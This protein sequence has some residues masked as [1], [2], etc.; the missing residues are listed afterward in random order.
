MFAQDWSDIGTVSVGLE[1]QPLGS[2]NDGLGVMDRLALRLEQVEAQLHG[3][4]VY[5]RAVDCLQQI[6]AERGADV[7]ML[8]RAIGREA[9]R[10][11][12]Q[13]SNNDDATVIQV[14]QM[15]VVVEIDSDPRLSEATLGSDLAQ[16]TDSG[17]TVGKLNALQT[18]ILKC[19]RKSPAEAV[20]AEPL[21]PTREQCLIALGQAVAKAREEKTMTLA[22]LHART[23][24]PLYHLQAL[25]RGEV[26]RLPQDIYLKGFLRRI[27]NALV[28]ESG[29]LMAYLP[30]EEALESGIL[31]SWVK[32]KAI[33]PKPSKNIAGLEVNSAHLYLA[34]TAIMAGGICW[35]SGQSA[36]KNN[37]API[38]I[39]EFR[40]NG[41]PVQVK[42]DSLRL[43]KTTAAQSSKGHQATKAK[44]PIKVSVAPPE[45]MR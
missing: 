45:A 3:S 32:G 16:A 40:P 10:L 2:A 43:P 20:E 38:Q 41:A 25:E 36:P 8:I 11:A 5:G 34:Y 14:T 23:F 29:T 42:A 37:L 13:A 21:P 44:A 18:L 39:D 1:V 9:I 15:P 12:L 35:I 27:E 30:D 31:P 19:Q 24:V 4:D 26:D 28:L 7:Q 17:S 6:A 22:Q 33:L